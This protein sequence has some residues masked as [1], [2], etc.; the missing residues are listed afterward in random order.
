[1]FTTTKTFS[2]KTGKTENG[3][4]TF[5]RRNLISHV[6]TF[7]MTTEDKENKSEMYDILISR[8]SAKE[9]EEY[10]QEYGDTH[11]MFC[12][13]KK[14]SNKTEYIKDMGAGKLTTEQNRDKNDIKKSMSYDLEKQFKTKQI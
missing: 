10:A 7:D 13:M 11:F 6:K 8:F 9:I 4:F 14:R 12:Q 1:M 3:L 2:K 5:D